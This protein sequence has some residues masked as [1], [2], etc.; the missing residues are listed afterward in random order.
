[1]HLPVAAMDDTWTDMPALQSTRETQAQAVLDRDSRLS[2]VPQLVAMNPFPSFKFGASG[3]ADHTWI[4]A[5]ASSLN[6]VPGAP[7]QYAA[8]NS[9]SFHPVRDAS[10]Q[11]QWL[12]HGMDVYPPPPL[13]PCGMPAS[14]VLAPGSSGGGPLNIDFPSRA[15]PGV[16][17]GSGG[18]R[19]A[20]STHGAT[21]TPPA[22]STFTAEEGSRSRQAASE[23]CRAEYGASPQGSPQGHQHVG[24]SHQQQVGA[25]AA[26]PS[27]GETGTPPAER[28]STGEESLGGRPAASETGRAAYGT[29]PQGPPQFHQ[30]V[31]GSHLQHG[32]SSYSVGKGCYERRAKGARGSGSPSVVGSR[33]ADEAVHVATSRSGGLDVS[34]VPNGFPRGPFPV[35]AAG[36]KAQVSAYTEAADCPMGGGFNVCLIRPQKN[37]TGL[38]YRRTLACTHRG[39]AKSGFNCTWE[40]TYEWSTE[41]W[42]LVQYHRHRHEEVSP[43]SDPEVSSKTTSIPSNHHNHALMESMT[44]VRAQHG[45]QCRLPVDLVPIGEMMSKAGCSTAEIKRVFDSYAEEHNLDRTMYSYD[46]IARVFNRVDRSEADLDLDGL[47]QHLKEREEELGLNYEL[48]VD[49]SGN[50]EMCFAQLADAMKDWARGGKSNI[51]LFD[52]TAGTNRLGMKLCMFVTV[53]PTGKTT[54][55]ALA[56][57]RTENSQSFEWCL[58]CFAKAFRTPPSLFITDSDDQIAAAVEI[59]RKPGDVWPGVVHNLCV[60]HISKNLHG[61]LRKLFGANLKGWHELLNKFWRIA[62]ESDITSRESFDADWEA[63]CA[64]IIRTATA[65]EKLNHEMDWLQTRLYVRR[66]KWAARWVFGQFTAGCHSTQRAE[67]NQAAKKA[68]LRK[69]AKV[70]ALMTHVERENVAG[71]DKAAISEEVLRMRQSITGGASIAVVRSLMNTLT[72]YAFKLVLEQAAQAVFY[73]SK[74]CDFDDGEPD[75]IPRTVVERVNPR[76]D[77]PPHLRTMRGR[78]LFE[79]VERR[80]YYDSAYYAPAYLVQYAER[81]ACRVVYEHGGV[82]CYSCWCGC[83][84]FR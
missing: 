17:R 65:S 28:T 49:S 69:N 25:R 73:T 22:G 15:F 1:M 62:K 26:T 72:P 51:L 4:S 31:S 82:L 12:F 8:N 66:H 59:V 6:D 68:S 76:Y 47:S 63:M 64:F 16:A 7:Q 3:V 61:H 13:Q 34:E 48:N 55:A 53:S 74:E 20:T 77:P 70:S 23:A 18:A 46:Y 36:L 79:E 30:D 50:L 42:V 80:Q 2:G 10:N 57:I 41:G 58:R 14:P 19:A 83:V 37:S 27:Q 52:P 84:T 21:S 60:F 35:D 75:S 71:R 44:Q 54:T 24:A 29:S 81:R 33:T 56:L 45:G 39:G 38:V 9:G 43:T 67:S 11:E 78:V 40:A 32:W 5:G